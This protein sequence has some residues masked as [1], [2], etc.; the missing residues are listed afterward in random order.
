VRIWSMVSAG[1]AMAKLRCRKKADS[2]TDDRERNAGVTSIG[3]R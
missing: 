1:A 3:E 2:G